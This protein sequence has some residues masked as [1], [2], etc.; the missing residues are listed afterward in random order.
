MM[1]RLLL[2]EWT[3]RLRLAAAALALCALAACGGG[4]P[5]EDVAASPAPSEEQ[6]DG[7]RH[8]ADLLGSRLQGRL[9]AAMQEGGPHAAVAVCAEEAPVIAAEVSAETGYQVGRT[10]LRTRNPGNAPDEWEQA[11]LTAFMA[12]LADG[13]PPGELEVAEF[14]TAA[15]GTDVFRWARPIPLQ[16]PCATCHGEAVDPDLLADIQARY[17]EDMATGFA[18]GELRGMFTVSR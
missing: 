12:A 10:A 6:I 7:A 16:P 1:A 14:V 4:E 9:M 17:P 3:R 2:T 18:V 11:Q 15:D 13:T 8:A 5:E